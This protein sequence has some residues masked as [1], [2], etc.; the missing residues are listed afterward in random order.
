MSSLVALLFVTGCNKQSS[1]VGPSSSGSWTEVTGLPGFYNIIASGSNLYA[2]GSYGIFI[3][4]DEGNTWA[5]LD[6]SLSGSFTIAA[7]NGDLF[8]GDYASQNGIFRSTDGGATWVAAD[9]GLGTPYAGLYQTI[10]C[11]GS[12]G[13]T[14]FAGTVSNG[15]FKS[16]DNGESWSAANNGVSYNTT[17]FSFAVAGSNVIAG[18]RYG[19]YLSS[20]DG[21]TWVADDSGLVNSS[22]Y[23]SSLYV[24][25]LAVNGSTVYAGAWGTQ[26]FISDDDGL[27]WLE[28][29]SNLPGSSQSGIGVAASDSSLVVVDDN[30]VF[31]ST[32]T[33]S[34]W[35]NV[36]GNL[37][38]TGI[39]AFDEA[40]GYLFIQMSDGSVWRRPF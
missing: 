39:S 21:E 2:A 38:N 20:D 25:S 9:S 30:G 27:S 6:T 18:T 28:I 3:S 7:V 23:F 8:I 4:T 17:V 22:P 24:V 35:S 36:S 12:N 29:S 32:N 11:I 19:T 31:L 26:V 1:I 37:P 5:V 40:D 10:N 16:T 34:S 14:I 13:K 15:I 33:G